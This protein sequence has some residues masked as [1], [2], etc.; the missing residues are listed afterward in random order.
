VGLLA[1]HEF[2]REHREIYR[3]VPECEMIDPKVSLWY[4]KRVAQ[5]YIQGLQQGIDRKEIR[6]LPAVFL[7]RSIMGLTHFIGLK[8]IVWNASAHP[9]IPGPLLTDIVEFVL[10]G[11]KP[12]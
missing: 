11:L 8:W 10:F 2:L 5:G 9:R 7:G 1:F 12:R 3:V 4:Y 6:D